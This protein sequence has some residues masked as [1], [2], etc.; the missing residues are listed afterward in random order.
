MT[1]YGDVLSFTWSNNG[2]L[3]DSSYHSVFGTQKTEYFY[4]DSGNR[5]AKTEYAVDSYDDINSSKKHF[6]Y[7]N[8]NLVYQAYVSRS[9]EPEEPINFLYNSTGVIGFFYNHELYTYRKNLFG[10][11]TEI[12]KGSELVVKYKYDAWGNHKV[13]DKNDVEATNEAFIGYLNPLRYRGYYYDNLTGLYYL[14]ARYYDP[15]IGRFISPDGIEY[16]EPDNVNGLNLYAYCANNPVMYV[17]PS[18]HSW[19]WSTF[20]QALGYLVTGIGAIFS[21]ALV[22]ASGVATL[23]MLLV[24][25]I[26]IGAG[27]LTTVNGVAEVGDLAFGYNFIED[28]LFRGNTAAYNT[29]ASI[30]GSIATVGSIVCGAWY[31]YNTPRIQA[32]KNIANTEF[33][34]NYYA[35]KIVSRP[36]FNSVLTQKN[37]IKY[38]KMSKVIGKNGKL[39]YSFTAKGSSLINGVFNE[40]IYELTLTSDYKLIWHLLFKGG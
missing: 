24:A 29:Y 4:D 14:K 30:T 18:G 27:A 23:P 9:N 25:G 19:E 39:F 28:G 17:D 1:E 8:G 15:T 35:D 40:G 31:K 6:R 10:D 12:Y 21:G 3:S 22:V 26:T 7:L 32:Y 38:G 36:Y 13:C 34:G 11:I 5:V 20:G 2:S 33:P 16:L 37:I